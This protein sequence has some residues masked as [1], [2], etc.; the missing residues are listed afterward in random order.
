[1]YKKF[2]CSILFLIFFS[3]N[4]QQSYAYD[5]KKDYFEKIN[6]KVDVTNTTPI[7]LNDN[8]LFFPGNYFDP[9]AKI[10]NIKEKKLIDK[11]V[12]MNIPRNGYL[13]VLL[14]DGTVLIVGGTIDGKATNIA[15]IY[16]PQTNTFI[17]INNSN[18]NYY[19]F[20]NIVKLKDGRVL[21]LGICTAEIY[22]PK[23]KIFTLAGNKKRINNATNQEICYTNDRHVSPCI[24]LLDDGRVLIYDATFDDAKKNNR[25]ELFD[26]QINDFI[27]VDYPNK[28]TIHYNMFRLYY[29][30]VKLKD[31][32]IL[33]FGSYNQRSFMTMFLPKTNEFKKIVAIDEVPVNS[34][35]IFINNKVLLF[36]GILPHSKK[37]TYLVSAIYD[38]DKRKII[39]KKTSSTEKYIKFIFD[40]GEHS[41]ILLGYQDNSPRIYKIK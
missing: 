20:D 36:G 19:S 35:A 17:K 14:D 30:G 10:L 23:R 37:P 11:K 31:G 29:T 2:L 40:I 21:L 4:F 15:E 18:F 28:K 26:P 41:L 27:T 38:I 9:H 1:M 24:F 7:K 5:F 33:T 16:N 8:E 25:I 22:N 12:S 39:N 13:S 34:K 6:L 3:I 32:N